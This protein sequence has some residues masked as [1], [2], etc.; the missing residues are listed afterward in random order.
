VAGD[1]HETESQLFAIRAG[2]FEVRESQV[3]GYSAAFFFLQ[4]VGVNPGEGLDQSGL[5]VIDV[6]RGADD[7]GLHRIPSISAQTQIHRRD[8]KA[9]EKFP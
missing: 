9:A 8:A 5:P 6:P 3:N 7:D 2:Q 4:T 1:I